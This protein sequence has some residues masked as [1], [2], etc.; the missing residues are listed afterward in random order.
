MAVHCECVCHELDIPETY[1]IFRYLEIGCEAIDFGETFP[2]FSLLSFL[3]TLLL[4]DEF[5]WPRIFQLN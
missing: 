2:I 5:Q 4:F 1:R 3:I